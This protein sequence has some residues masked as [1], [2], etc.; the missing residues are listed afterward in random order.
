[1]KADVAKYSPFVDNFYLEILLGCT[2]QVQADIDEE[3]MVL[4]Y[5]SNQREFG[6][7]MLKGAL[8][9]SEQF[10]YLHRKGRKAYK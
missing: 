3:R 8:T 10:W 2:T 1:M 7:N 5:K 6:Y 4:Q 9:R